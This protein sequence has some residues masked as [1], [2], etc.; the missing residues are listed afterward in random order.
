MRLRWKKGRRKTFLGVCVVYGCFFVLTCKV[1]EGQSRKL[2]EKHKET[3]F[4]ERSFVVLDKRYWV[5]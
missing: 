4:G 3:N 1:I 2:E 5:K